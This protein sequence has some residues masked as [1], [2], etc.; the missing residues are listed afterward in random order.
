MKPAIL[1][2]PLSLSGALFSAL[3]VPASAQ[4]DAGTPPL[5]PNMTMPL[6]QVLKLP[7]GAQPAVLTTSQSQ[8]KSGQ[9]VRITFRVQN[10]SNKPVTYDFGTGQRYDITLSNPAGTQVWSWAHGKL[11]S[12]NLSV[13]HLAP[14]QSL[15]YRA[16]CNGRDLSGHPLAP[17]T[18]TLNAHLTSDN[19]PAIT[20]GVIVNT[21]PDPTN[22]GQ[23]TRTPAESGA[24][25]QVDPA[26]QVSA[27]TM[28]VI[29]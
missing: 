18:Y 20:G 1:L 10:T 5:T 8:Y 23:P 26:P 24:V 19:P 14:N 29:K 17:G 12:Q 16:V 3:A 25:R 15:V 22:M 6:P 9:P 11:F 7:A 13:I 21:D 28:V 4:T 2:L 27:K